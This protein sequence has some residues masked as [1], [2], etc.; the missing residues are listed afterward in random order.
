MTPEGKVKAEVKKVLACFGPYVYAHWPV[1]N[2]MGAPTLDCIGCVGGKFFAIET[3]AAGKELTPRQHETRDRMVAAG[4]R[5]FV[6]AGTDDIALKAFTAWLAKQL[7][8]ST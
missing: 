8:E 6:I 5:V 1:L 7:R 2:G 3:K 4:G